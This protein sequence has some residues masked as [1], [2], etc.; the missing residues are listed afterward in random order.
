MGAILFTSTFIVIHVVVVFF[1]LQPRTLGV[2][3]GQ[4]T[5]EIIAVT[6]WS[7]TWEVG[8]SIWDFW[9]NAV[10]SWIVDED[11]QY[12]KNITGKRRETVVKA[13]GNFG[14]SLGTFIGLAVV[15]AYVIGDSVCN[16]NYSHD[17]Q[18][19]ACQNGLF[20]F[21]GLIIPAVRILVVVLI[22]FFPITGER[23]KQL[24]IN[25]G[26]TQ[27]ALPGT[28]SELTVVTSAAV[29]AGGS[30][31]VQLT[32]PEGAT[33]GMTL[34]M[35]LPDGRNVQCTVPENGKGGDVVQCPYVVVKEVTEAQ[36]MPDAVPTNGDT[37]V[38]ALEVEA[39]KVE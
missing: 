33:P 2:E 24:Y 30:N 20:Y 12:N 18:T 17:N 36:V 37:E 15:N 9:N 25:Q 26:Q 10:Q 21:W 39:A 11:V 38:A 19:P 32:L 22:Y 29:N 27:L 28:D 7:I 23:L 31:T 35:T 3:I 5:S 34:S 4:G 16:T 14:A 8:S 13:L 1:M 6:V